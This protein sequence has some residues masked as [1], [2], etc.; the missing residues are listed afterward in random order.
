MQRVLF[1][2]LLASSLVLFS[3]PAQSTPIAHRFFAKLES[4]CGD[5]N[6]PYARFE[7]GMTYPEDGQDSFADKMLVAEFKQC[8]KTEIRVPFIV[9]ED[10]SRTWV[11]SKTATGAR[12]KHDHR[13]ADGTPDEVTNYGGDSAGHGTMFRQSFAAD[14]YT[15]ML[16]PEAETNVWTLSL[17]ADLKTLTYHLE[18]YGAPRFTAILYRVETE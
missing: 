13:H 10:T 4:L 12:L 6:H 1:V 16:I 15:A 11:F 8:S 18:R 2:L 7:G 14:D 5:S 17:S 3:I 9:G